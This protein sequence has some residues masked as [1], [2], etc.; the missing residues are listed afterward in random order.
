M[1]SS[2]G[3]RHS[4]TRPGKSRKLVIKGLKDVPTLPANFEQDAW[5]RISRA[6]QAIHSQSPLADVKEGLYRH[7]LEVRLYHRVKDQQYQYAREVGQGLVQYAKSSPPPSPKIWLG[8]VQG[9]WKQYGQKLLA[10][11]AILLPMDRSIPGEGGGAKGLSPVYE[12]G[13]EAFA[14]Q[15]LL[16]LCVSRIQQAL[17]SLLNEERGNFTQPECLK[18]ISYQDGLI[19]PADARVPDPDRES[20]LHGIIRMYR[21]MELFHSTLEPLLTSSTQKYYQQEGEVCFGSQALSPILF[22]RWIQHR[23]LEEYDLECRLSL[24]SSTISSLCQCVDQGLALPWISKVLDKCFSSI[25]EGTEQQQQQQH[26][27]DKS[28]QCLLTLVYTIFSRVG[29]VPDL[30]QRYRTYLEKR[31]STLLS[32]ETSQSSLPR[33]I[34]QLLEIYHQLQ[35]LLNQC[36]SEE[37]AASFQWARN[38]AMRVGMRTSPNGVAEA[39]ARWMDQ[40]L[41]SSKKAVREITDEPSTSSSM[42]WLTEALILFRFLQSKDVF[43]AIYKLALS[44]RLLLARSASIDQEKAVLDRLTTECGSNFTRRLKG[45]FTDMKTSKDLMQQFRQSDYGRRIS[46]DGL[47]FHVHVLSQAHWPSYPLIQGIILPPDLLK[48]K[49][50]FTSFYQGNTR[51]RRLQWQPSLD[52]CLVRANLP[53]GRK[54]LSVS[55]YQALVLYLFN[56]SP[57]DSG[58]GEEIVLSVQ[59]IENRTGLRGKELRRTLQS[60]ACGKTRLLQ[61]MPKGREVGPKDQFSLRLNFTSPLIRLRIP[62]VLESTGQGEE[63]R[64][65]TKQRVQQDR[66]YQMDASI[67]RIMKAR[68]SLSH[69]HLILEL[70][71]QLNFFIPELEIKKRIESL[72]EREYMERSAEDQQL[73]LYV[74]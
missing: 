70:Y 43:E 59:E 57:K 67:V 65:R 71:D 60:L 41:Q 37:D 68:R 72:I 47:G 28:Q 74:S 27:S 39:L 16:P 26:S 17:V 29:R 36:V 50:S 42:T 5:S 46:K 53:K 73:Y 21:D 38:E 22:L 20:I 24:P 69:Q 32:Q 8:H 58:E 23:W 35:P 61:K 40:R 10:I 2:S 55:L 49:D 31:I 12:M 48:A 30:I 34:P 66:Q 44:R 63:E 1:N 25:M 7:H 6:I 18:G 51:G 4:S 3:R 19:I 14:T 62:M 56:L 64:E 9:V 45:M 13:L 52:H 15:A 54:E 11:R 33:W